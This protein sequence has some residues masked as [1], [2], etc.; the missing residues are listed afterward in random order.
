MRNEGWTFGD[1]AGE[2]WSRGIDINDVDPF[3]VYDSC[4]I[5]TPERAA[6]YIERHFEGRED[7]RD[8]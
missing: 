5:R 7:R 4:L 1:L 8:E 6:N 3:T 2:L